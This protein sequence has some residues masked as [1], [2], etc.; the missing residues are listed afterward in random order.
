[1]ALPTI[2]LREFQTAT[3]SDWIPGKLAQTYKQLES[4]TFGILSRNATEWN[5]HF[6][7]EDDVCEGKALRLL[8][9]NG[10]YFDNDCL[11][12]G[13]LHLYA[14]FV[15]K[16]V[17]ILASQTRTSSTA[18]S[19]RITTN[20]SSRRV[21]QSSPMTTL[22]EVDLPLS[23]RQYPPVHPRSIISIPQKRKRANVHDLSDSDSEGSG[24][25]QFILSASDRGR[26][27]DEDEEEEDDYTAVPQ[28]GS[29]VTQKQPQSNGKAMQHAVDFSTAITTNAPCGKYG[30]KK[31]WE[32]L[33]D[34]HKHRLAHARLIKG[35]HG[36]PSPSPCTRCEQ[37]GLVCRTYHLGLKTTR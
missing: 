33:A 9:D 5:V 2:L 12:G 1:M 16:D 28:P 4:L 35:T 15:R 17:R 37:R 14:H 19:S 7:L 27:S 18:P 30:H 8:W 25:T 24:E 23:P 26:D 36:C 22:G 31:D 34:E 11:K 29:N 32:L 10:A 20:V 13:K 6:H 3:I 21:T